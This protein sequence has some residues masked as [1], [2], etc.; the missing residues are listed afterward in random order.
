VN[1]GKDFG[2]SGMTFGYGMIEMQGC[3][4]GKNCNGYGVPVIRISNSVLCAAYETCTSRVI[5]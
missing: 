3:S 1:G 5:S 4:S 2:I